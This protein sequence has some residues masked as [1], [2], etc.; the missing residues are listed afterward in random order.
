MNEFFARSRSLLL[1][2]AVAMLTSMCTV[3]TSYAASSPVAGGGLSTA[4]HHGSTAS[5]TSA[6]QCTLVPALTCRST[7]PAVDLNIDY[8]G[9][10]A[11][12]IFS[13]DVLWG[14]GHSSLNLVVTQPADGYR[15]LAQHTY[16]AAKKYTI[17]VTGQMIA[18]N[19]VAN[20]FTAQFTLLTA[21]APAVTVTDRPWNGY[22]TNWTKT[23]K[24]F[25][26]AGAYW[27]VPNNKCGSLSIHTNLTSAGQW[28]GLGGVGTPVV[29]AGVVST[30]QHGLQVNAPVWEV[31]PPQIS[32]QPI[33]HLVFAGDQMIASV[34]YLGNG[35]YRLSLGDNTRGWLWSRTVSGP[36][37]VPNTADWAVEAGGAPL[38]DFNSV[39]FTD[40]SYATGKHG[41]TF[42]TSGIDPVKFE[43]KGKKG[44]ETR[45][46]S[47]ST[48][49]TFTV[50]YLRS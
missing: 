19:C 8:Y 49:G 32:V 1:I 30:C 41:G 4:V 47:I 33:L 3:S 17:A 24:T 26:D 13:W 35:N 43:T 25:Y 23:P 9:N 29:Q 31:T 39:T 38:A 46:S 34:Q 5:A 18:G 36:K 14:D 10:T 37:S 45:V 44:L 6:S 15:L 2:A 7:D 27:R 40:C 20:D 22:T 50:K 48:T 11:G 12:C 42:L 21:P 28:V 16:A